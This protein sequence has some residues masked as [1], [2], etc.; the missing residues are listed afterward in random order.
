MTKEPTFARQ[1]VRIDMGKMGRV[2]SD[3]TPVTRDAQCECG[4]M[5][6]Q[7]QLSPAWLE[8][9][10]RVARNPRRAIQAIQRQIPDYYVP[11]HCPPCE[12]IDIGRQALID[13][14]VHEYPPADA[15]RLL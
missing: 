13:E 2:H 11:V 14:H 15:P 12:R 4:Q 7:Q 3:G 5:F 9:V 6:R 10:E 8:W 1:P